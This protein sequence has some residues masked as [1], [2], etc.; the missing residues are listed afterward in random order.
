MQDGQQP[1]TT[2][3]LSMLLAGEIYQKQ[4]IQNLEQG[5]QITMWQ[6]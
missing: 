5:T 3:L 4:Q 1:L 6:T 2:I